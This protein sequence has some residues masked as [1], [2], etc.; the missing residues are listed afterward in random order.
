MCSRTSIV[1]I[2]L[3]LGLAV[4]A[5]PGLR[6]ADYPVG[7]KPEGLIAVDLNHDGCL[8]LASADSQANQVSVLLGLGNGGFAAPQAYPTGRNPLWVAA[9]DFDRDGHP[10]L[11]VANNKDDSVSVLPGDGTGAFGA[12]TEYAV[13]RRPEWVGALDLDGDSRAD[14]VTVNNLDDELSVLLAL[15]TGGFAAET[16]YATGMKPRSA[17]YGDL[18]GDGDNDLVVTRA[19]GTISVFLGDGAG[20]L[21][22]DAEYGVG[23]GTETVHLADL[24]GDGRLDAATANRTGND[25]TVLPGLGNATFGSGSSYPVGS[26]ASITS[27]DFNGDCLVDLLVSAGTAGELNLLPGDGD[28]NFG[29]AET[30]AVAAHSSRLVVA[31]L[32]GDLRWDAAV[33][34]NTA[35]SVSVFLGAGTQACTSFVV[36]RAADP[37][38]VRS[39]VPLN[40]VGYAPFDGEA[41]QLSSPESYF[42][43]IEH[44]GGLDTRLS[45][46]ANRADGSIR[47]GFNDGD[48]LSAPVDAIYSGIDT[49]AGA[50]SA[51]GSK[52]LDVTVVPRDVNGV[53]V[54]TGLAITVDE[55]ALL[56]GVIRGAARDLGTGRY[57]LRVVS[58][59]AGIGTVRLD[60]EGVPLSGTASVEFLA[61]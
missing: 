21:L 50:V 36:R 39:A 30:W 47:L 58:S 35:N 61:P 11:V 15:P 20:G 32:D 8:D 27:G 48:P 5:A 43:V 33:T 60:I 16:T 54:G 19:A 34:R 7:K 45:V 28:G 37:S 38:T 4:P 52:A 10:D 44:A 56:P 18:D 42:Y 40:T 25:V 9:A 22:L 53:P 59:A 26:P 31:D 49:P 6:A 2:A 51:D 23:S 24:D 29:A 55:V 14:L 13:G 3:L 57:L 46:H 12:A 17:A 1:G 41:D